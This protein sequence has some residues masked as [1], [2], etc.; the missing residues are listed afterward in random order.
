METF[1]T[2]I[3][4]IFVGFWLLGRISRW[5]LHWWITKKQREFQQQFGGDNASAGSSFGNGSF[6]G[7]HTHFGNAGQKAKRRKDGEV[8]VTH[9]TIHTEYQVNK[10]AGEYVEYE[11]VT[12]QT[13]ATHSDSDE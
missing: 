13:T 4:F 9:T 12:T 11:E 6:R 8:T 2:V 1:L 5:T 10:K 3:L 7:F